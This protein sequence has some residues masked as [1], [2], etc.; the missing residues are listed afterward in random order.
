MAFRTS[1]RRMCASLCRWT[2]FRSCLPKISL[3][4]LWTL[5]NSG[6]ALAKGRRLLTKTRNTAR[7]ADLK[8][9][10]A[11]WAAASGSQLTDGTQNKMLRTCRDQ[12]RYYS[13]AVSVCAAEQRGKISGSP[14]AIPHSVAMPSTRTWHRG[15]CKASGITCHVVAVHQAEI[16]FGFRAQLQPIERRIRRHRR[17]AASAPAGGRTASGRRTPSRTALT[18]STM[19][20]ASFGWITCSSAGLP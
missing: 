5:R 1:R 18:I 19:I 8:Q 14:R 6:R 17:C 2:G 10:Y 9:L 4:L 15:G 11:V 3:Q 20:P 13:S 16:E 12:S 7:P